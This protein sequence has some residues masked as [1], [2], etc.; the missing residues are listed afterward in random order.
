M[1]VNLLLVL[2]IFFKDFINRYL[3]HEVEL[4]EKIKKEEREAMK[5]LRQLLHDYFVAFNE[6]VLQATLYFKGNANNESI[7][8]KS[9][10]KYNS[11]NRD[12][13]H[14]KPDLTKPIRDKLDKIM[15]EA[16]KVLINAIG[17]EDYVTGV[18]KI[19]FEQFTS[20]IISVQNDCL[21]FIN[22]IERSINK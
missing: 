21:N 14:L 13:I 8:N 3:F 16:A 19:N 9:K 12:L 11:F 10:E 4:K 2:V 17:I 6:H 15:L 20:S 5:K 22:E 7:F 1:T 18:R